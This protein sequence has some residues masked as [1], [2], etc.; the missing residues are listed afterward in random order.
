MQHLF[1]HPLYL[2]L[3]VDVLRMIQNNNNYQHI[4]C[5]YS[6]NIHHHHGM[7]DI[8][9]SIKHHSQSTSDSAASRRQLL[10]EVLVIGIG[11]WDLD[12]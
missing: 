6:Y 1:L 5:G 8:I 4:H 7:L 9:A 2:I 10:V 11:G 12:I 3:Y